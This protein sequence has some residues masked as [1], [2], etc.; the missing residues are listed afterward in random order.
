MASSASLFGVP[1][2]PPQALLAKR[3]CPD[4]PA[5]I[6][7]CNIEKFLVFVSG[8]S[9]NKEVNNLLQWLFKSVFNK[10]H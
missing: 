6:A 10:L 1:P 9:P 3:H 5:L 2:T 7:E 8:C 4:T